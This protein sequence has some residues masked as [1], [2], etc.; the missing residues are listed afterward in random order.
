VTNGKITALK[1][2]LTEKESRNAFLEKTL[3]GLSLRMEGQAHPVFYDIGLDHTILSLP[4]YPPHYPHVTAVKKE[5]ENWRFFYFE[6]RERMRAANPSKE[7]NHLG[8]MGEDLAAY[9][10]T[11][12]NKDQTKSRFK[13]IERAVHSIIPSIERIETEINSKTGEVELLVYENGIPISSR[14]LSEGTLRLIGLLSISSG[15]D[16]PSVICFEEPE[17]GV[18]PRR[19]KM[20]AEYLKTASDCNG[21]QERR[22][23]IIGKT[24]NKLSHIPIIPAI[25]DPHVE[26][27]LLI[28]SH[29]FKM[30]PN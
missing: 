10:N 13:A 22:K 15:D 8:M 6:P 3:N 5:M 21:Y 24:Y 2:N 30:E 9:L 29:A 17:N 14:L 7:I 11:I 1:S 25:P 16:R 26:R 27:W 12:K 19:I 23:E 20:I 4:L 18:H 28:D